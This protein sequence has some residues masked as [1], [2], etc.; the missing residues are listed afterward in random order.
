MNEREA[1][2]P[3]PKRE[4]FGLKRALE[5]SEY[6][7]IGCHKLVVKTDV[8]YIHGM[9]NHPETGPNTTIN[10][11]IEKIL[12]FHFEPKHVSGKTFG[13]DGLSRRDEQPGEKQ[14]PPDEDLA[15][16]S[17]PPVLRIAEGSE[18]PLELDVFKDQID[19]RGGYLR[20]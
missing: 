18:L 11:W 10:R 14:Y 19:T 9:L 12:M 8:K 15:E 3:Q 20:N 17:K 1:H 2:F 5:A 6:L 13:P 4:L 7:L 16:I